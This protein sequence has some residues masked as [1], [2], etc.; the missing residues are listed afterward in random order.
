MTSARSSV[1]ATLVASA[2]ISGCAP[3]IPPG[4]G[5]RAQ[6]PE[7]TV[8]QQQ[9]LTEALLQRLEQPSAP[10]RAA[11]AGAT[12]PASEAPISEAQ[13]AQRF[14]GLPALA[15][16]VV[17]EGRR[18][19]F[20][21]DGSRYIDAE[22]EIVRYG[23]DASSGDV[24][25][26]AQTGPDSFVLKSVRVTT[27]HAPVTIATAS[28][29]NGLWQIDT[30]T[31]K[32]LRGWRLIPLARGVL[33]GR[34]NT[35]FAW[36]AG[37]GTK[38]FAAPESFDLAGFQNG[39]VAGTGYVLLER[40]REAPQGALG[41]TLAA[42]S[43]LGNALGATRQEDYALYSMSTG[44]LH[45]LDIA[46]D[47]KTTSVHSQCRQKNAVLRLCDRV[48]FVDSLYDQQGLPNFSHYFWRV[49]WYRTARGPIA[50]AQEAGL[51][52]ITV[53]D[54]ATG[55]KAVAFT[56]MLGI[57]GFTSRQDAN[58]R[59]SVVAQMGFDK[60]VLDDATSVLSGANA[61]VQAR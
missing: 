17:I 1:L 25:Y 57:A 24:T 56:R 38:S 43:A 32:T 48:D 46:A 8:E 6:Q 58:G 37:E 16:R 15:S 51:K 61:Q 22:G 31:G 7:L 35:G 18:D 34:D 40:R 2:L 3:M 21:V 47:G 28:R 23:F 45:P 29:R 10:G 53:T 11:A 14:V 20:A 9:R 5:S 52:H 36:V 27:G 50:I 33:V 60:Q 49:S 54:L 55:Q 59:V 44:Q 30:V 12:S 4:F 26:L 13:L 19:G 41:E 39:D 42:L